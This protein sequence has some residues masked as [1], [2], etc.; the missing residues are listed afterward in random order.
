MWLLCVQFAPVKYLRVCERT[1]FFLFF[2]GVK[3]WTCCWLWVKRNSV[4]ALWI[5]DRSHRWCHLLLKRQL[6][7]VHEGTAAPATGHKAAVC[8]TFS[9]PYS[10]EWTGHHPTWSDV[11]QLVLT[12]TSAGAFIVKRLWTCDTNL[13][14]TLSFFFFPRTLRWLDCSWFFFKRKKEKK[15]S[16]L[17]YSLSCGTVPSVSQIFFFSF[18]ACLLLPLISCFKVKPAF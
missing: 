9:D 17:V 10:R 2:P 3:I 16:F 7:D 18:F 15:K 8:R 4:F 11:G 12:P 1:L 13:T 14:M 6:S 5:E